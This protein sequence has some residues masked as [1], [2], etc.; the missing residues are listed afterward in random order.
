MYKLVISSSRDLQRIRTFFHSG[1]IRCRDR[2]LAV[3]GWPVEEHSFSA[4][5]GF[6]QA[7]AL[8][9]THGALVGVEGLGPDL[10]ESE[11]VESVVKAGG[12][13][14][15]SEPS[16]PA[17]SLADDESKLAAMGLVAVE[18]DVADQDAGTDSSEPDQ[19]GG[20]GLDQHLVETSI[21]GMR[22]VSGP[23]SRPAEL[24][25]C[26]PSRH[27]GGVAQV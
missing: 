13:S 22:Q 26:R 12:G 21:L 20:R 4:A 14:K 9:D 3:M 27:H 24:R 11:L 5:A 1:P 8:Q 19:V 2:E 23:A 15:P 18:I 17:R 25:V 16:T 10:L 6:D 7:E